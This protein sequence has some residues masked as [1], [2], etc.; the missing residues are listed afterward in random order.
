[1][2]IFKTESEALKA[3]KR[4]VAEL[5]K[6]ETQYSLRILKTEHTTYSGFKAL[7]VPAQV[8][9]MSGVLPFYI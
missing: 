3:A 1:M 5:N 2:T 7:I 6:G 8:K 4:K 9:W